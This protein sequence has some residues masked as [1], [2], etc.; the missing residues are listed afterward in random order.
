LNSSFALGTEQVHLQEQQRVLGFIPNFYAVYDSANA[1]PLSTALKFKLAM[2]VVLDPVT[3]TGV[4]FLS[5][6]KQAGDTPNYVQGAKGYGQR[7]AANAPDGFS[8]MPGV[9]LTAK[10][11]EFR[12]PAPLPGIG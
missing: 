9:F 4:G 5:G 8:D 3:I 2:R 7:F 10:R 11:S 12:W 1:V 6:V